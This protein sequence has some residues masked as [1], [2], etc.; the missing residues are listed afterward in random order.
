MVVLRVALLVLRWVALWVEPKADGMDAK[1][2]ALRV[3]L[4]AGKDEMKVGYLVVWMADPKASW[5]VS[6]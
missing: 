5:M 2:V 3:A 6:R 4:W 1:M